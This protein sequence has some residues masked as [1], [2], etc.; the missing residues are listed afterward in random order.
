M[1][2]LA[3]LLSQQ[4]IKRRIS[5]S[6]AS[7][8]L[9]IKPKYLESLEKGDWQNLPEPPFVKGFIKN[10][11]HYL[12]LD[13]QHVLALYR[14]EVD[15]KKYSQKPLEKSK[16]LMLTPNRIASLI[17]IAVAVIFVVYLFINYLSILSAPRLQ[18]TSPPDDLTTA[19]PSVVIAGRTDKEAT[20]SI[21]GKLV[22]VDSDGNFSFQLQLEEGQNII[23]IIASK[24]LAPKS[25]ASRTIRLTR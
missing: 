20:I 16:G 2:T 8:D 3:E 17:A 4:R 11:A 18:I 5:L 23:E 7:R 15:E 13:H 25:K 21:D 22:P 12:G 9:A 14:R 19:I 24:R 1:T 10:Y 6:R